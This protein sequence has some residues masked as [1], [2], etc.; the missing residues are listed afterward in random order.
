MLHMFILYLLV[1]GDEGVPETM[2]GAS[3]DHVKLIKKIFM[4]VFC[5]H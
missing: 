4:T 3:S 2:P 5:I 1:K